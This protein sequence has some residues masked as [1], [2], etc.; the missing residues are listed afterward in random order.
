MDRKR[1]RPE[2][3]T[4]FRDG[5]RAAKVRLSFWMTDHEIGAAMRDGRRSAAK[6]AGA[7]LLTWIAWGAAWAAVAGPEA[8]DCR[9]TEEPVTID[10]RLDEPAWQAAAVIEGFSIPWLEAGA[11]TPSRATRARLLWDRRN[12]YVAADME[13]GDLYADVTTHDGD[14]TRNDVFEIHLQPDAAKPAR[15]EFHVTPANTRLDL[16]VPRRGHEAR[17]L[18]AREFHL[19]SAIGLQGTLDRADDAD[20]G[21]TC[22]IRIPWADLMATGG[23]PEP[24][25]EW[26]FALGRR[27]Y[28][29]TREKPE[30][31]T[32]MPRS[33]GD[34]PDFRRHEDY[35]VIRFGAPG[36]HAGSRPFGFPAAVPVT[37]NRVVG[38]PDPPP[39]YT[40]ERMLPKA[41]LPCPVAVAQQP[42]TNL[43]LVITEP[44]SYQPTR[45]VRL[46][47]DPAAVET[48][49]LL[50]VDDPDA[51]KGTV[52]YS[53]TFH[54]RFAENGYVYIGSCG[55]YREGVPLPGPDV[56]GVAKKMTRV[57][58]YVI[59]RE[60]PYAF[61]PESAEVIIEWDSDG[62]NG[63]DMAFGP[64]GMLYVTSGD[65]SSDS[66]VDFA[67][68]DLARLRAKV[69]RIDVD[70]P[71]ED[72]PGDGRAYSVPAD[73]PFV[74]R[75]GVRPETW[76]YGMRNPWRIAV[77]PHTGQVWVG[78]NGQDLWE[79]VYLVERG[80][81]YG[82]SIVEGSH[83]FAP[84]RQRG[85][86]PIAKPIAEHSH[87]EARSLT[88]GVVYHGDALPE[89]R[90]CYLYGDYSTG[91]IWC[92][93]HDGT[94]VTRHDLL[95]D[96]TLQITG[97]HVDSAGEILVTD[98]QPG[99]SGG[100]YRLV[101]RPPQESRPPFP[102]RLTETGLFASVR[103]HAMAPGVIPYAVNA[104][105][106]SDG[107]HAVRYLALPSRP[108]PDGRPEPVPIDVVDT[109][110]WNF[111]DGTVVVNSFAIEEEE[112][113]PSTR[114]WI[115]TRLM[116][117]EAGEWAGYSY[118]WQDDQRD[119]VLVEAGGADRTFT[120]RTPDLATHP[121]G[122]RSRSWRFPSRAECM[123]CHSRA[124]NFVL[125]LSTVQFNRDFDYRAALG[126]GHSTDNQLRAFEHAGLLRSNWW[127]DAGWQLHGYTARKDFKPDESDK[128]K[129]A[130]E[131]AAEEKRRRELVA[132][133]I[134]SNDPDAGRFGGRRSRLLVKP[135]AAMM[136]LADPADHTESLAARARSYLH[137]NCSVCHVPAG[138]GNAQINL[139]FRTGLWEIPLDQ[140]KAVGERPTHA[141][142]GLPDAMLIAPGA[143][144]RSVLLAR[145][146]RRGPG[147]MPQL[148]SD[149]VDEAAV[150]LLREWIATVPP[151]KPKQ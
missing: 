115:E 27:D 23:R 17:F 111:P 89:L 59:D 47:H 8:Y 123:V 133:W 57:T 87:A 48:E 39:P 144:D 12:L 60:P 128:A 22:E 56:K 88:G 4:R 121:D 107:A 2:T 41:P 25:N 122:V 26:R 51:S 92:L 45:L 74:G 68:Q 90:G 98:H 30:L 134:A 18:Q 139:A 31:S 147:Q 86:D 1:F 77:D 145:V 3:A 38:G 103:D 131:Q 142:F 40:V 129:A 137:A 37:T 44:G 100:I 112:G 55:P 15:Y 148:G 91:R 14:T 140:M 69:L 53:I 149:V 28:D 75:A 50:E 143:P 84:E 109:Y 117:K 106:W 76:A 151:P 83:P 94:K 150:Q 105:Q 64:D 113:N 70:H 67:G 130:A 11:R 71:D 35:A 63:G 19:D 62:H 116:L 81:N 54:P 82:W 96:T 85:P 9:F 78:N 16:F 104:P 101:R 66:D 120:V 102:R 99:Q 136:R 97:F 65:G 114:R 132:R 13:D 20:Q 7:G 119:A 29:L 43:L 42:G 21:W 138:G 127:A 34:E 80:A 125:G 73:N 93:R 52:H 6:A 79:Q 135:P 146:S 124:A 108:G 141:T 126:E 72:V 32:S 5:C 49:T 36:A 58:R 10:G 46:R 110:G 118:Q 61:H 95:A 24:G 33:S